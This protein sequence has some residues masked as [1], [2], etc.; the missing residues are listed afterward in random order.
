MS[1]L[2]QQVVLKKAKRS[3]V[4]LK[5]GL[6]GASGS[7][8]TLSSLLLAFGLLERKY[9][10]LSPEELWEK[11]AIIDT[12][13]GSGELY[14]GTVVHGQKIGEYN[15][16]PLSA[17]FSPE[18]FIEAIDV[19]EKNGIEVAILDSASKVWTGEG[20]LLEE[21]ATAAKRSGNSYTAWRDVTPSHNRFV[22][23]LLQSKLH[24]IVTMRAKQEYVQEKGQDGRTSIRKVG[25]EPE[26]RKGIEFE[27]TTF[28]EINAEHEAFGAKDRMNLVADKTFVITPA[29]GSMMMEWLEGADLSSDVVIA[30][31]QV[32]PASSE[33]G[34]DGLKQ[35]MVEV[36]KS[37]GG[38]KNEALMKLISGFTPNASPNIN[39]IKD[40]QKL[41]AL[42][43]ALEDF[44]NDQAK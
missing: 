40:E 21:Q 8:K 11:I 26:M 34:A 38:S 16:I 30:T 1:N 33:V 2:N 13:N 42:Q 24:I 39:T 3:Q 44:K 10:T 7:G 19:C 36:I 43:V 14:V 18:K 41:K 5:L 15:A 28:L 22:E 25:L 17:P 31:S 6:S 32:R 37:L 27:F 20:G 4:F 35:S 9:P 29:T 23:K 12:E